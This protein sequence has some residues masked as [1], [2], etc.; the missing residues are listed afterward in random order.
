MRLV[1][2]DR[3][4]RQRG[5]ACAEQFPWLIDQVRRIHICSN[6]VLPAFVTGI[7]NCAPAPRMV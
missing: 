5:T 4:L 3:H 1:F 6:A 7:V 2:S